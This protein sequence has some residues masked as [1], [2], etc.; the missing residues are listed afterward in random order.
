MHRPGL[1]A[2]SAARFDAKRMSEL[3]IYPGWRDSDADWLLDGFR[4]LRD[5]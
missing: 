4:N 5:F 1:E 3:R 2:E